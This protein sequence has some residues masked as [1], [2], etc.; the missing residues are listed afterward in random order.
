MQKH[1]WQQ[2]WQE[3]Q[4]G[5]HEGRVNR[6]LEN[7]WPRLD[8]NSQETVFVP[9][10]G[11]AVDLV[12][13]RQRGH[14]VIGVELSERACQDFFAEQGLAPEINQ[15]GAFTRYAH[16]GLEILCGDF[17]DLKRE[18]LHGATLF[19][20]RAALIALPADMRPR[21]CEHLSGLMGDQSQ[22]LLVTLDYPPGDFSGPPFAVAESELRTLQEQNYAIDRLHHAPIPPNDPLRKRGLTE[23]TESVFKLTGTAL[24]APD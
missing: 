7:F 22:G 20:D 8:F 17:F 19:Y 18:H 5:F 13:L 21:Y 10:C 4:I 2:R 12:W 16:E 23:A 11:K 1:F 15:V 3:N 6:H 9:L 14:H 24:P